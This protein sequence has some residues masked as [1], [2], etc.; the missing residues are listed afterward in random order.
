MSW[1]TDRSETEIEIPFPKFYEGI[2][3]RVGRTKSL[4]LGQWTYKKITS[5]LT[6][7]TGIFGEERT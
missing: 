3:F 1:D 5:K 4:N 7:K 2:L 6:A